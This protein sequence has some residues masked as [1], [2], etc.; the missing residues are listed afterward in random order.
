M[1]YTPA[2][3]SQADAS[4]TNTLNNLTSANQNTFNTAAQGY[5]TAYQNVLNNPYAA[6]AQSGVNA[7]SAAG[8]G[9]GQTD[10]ANAATLNSYAPSIIA[11]GFDPTSA[12]YNNQLKSA[13]DAAA[14]SA[15]QSGVAGS[16]FGAGLVGD[17]STNFNLNW[18]AQ[19]AAKQQQAIAALS[20]LFGQSNT[21]ASAGATQMANSAIAPSAQYNANQGDILSALSQ[22]VS[23][24][25]NASTTLQND[26]SD[27]GKYLALGQNA[28]QLQDQAT[29]INNSSG[30]LLG[31]LGSIFGLATGGGGTLGG[32]LLGK[33]K[34]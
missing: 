34:L 30:G 12:L 15:A 18:Q 9:A 20:S 21:L 7:A 11:S 13:Q 31:G 29:Q 6:S 5:N 10:L 3:Q 28:T 16:P 14:I 23:G 19:R 24:M 32:D 1:A 8:Y 25:G 33:L 4:Y 26:V 17:A 27:Y 22:L 2:S